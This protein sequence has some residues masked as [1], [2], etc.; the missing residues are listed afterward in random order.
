MYVNESKDPL[1]LNLKNLFPS[2]DYHYIE[3]QNKNGG[4]TATWN[5]GI[6][7][8]KKHD[9]ETII[10]S[11]D[12]IVFSK[13]ILHILHV[14][15]N[16][17]NIKPKYYG[18]ITNNPGNRANRL[19]YGIESKNKSPYISQ[20]HKNYINLNGFFMVFSISILEKNKFNEKYYFDP[21]KPFA[22]NE[23]EWFN[24]FKRINGQPIIVPK[25]FIY[26]Y[27]LKTWR[28]NIQKNDK[29]I[30]TINT[31][32]Y[33]G[34]NIYIKGNNNYDTLY[35]TDNFN[36]FKKC[37]LLNIIPFLVVHSN[38]KLIQR[39]IKS[40][41]HIYLPMQYNTS[42]YIDGNCRF[43][44]KKN[45]FDYYKKYLQKYDIICFRHPRNNSI[46]KEMAEVNF[47]RLASHININKVKNI[48]DNDK[49]FN[50]KNLTET[51]VLI[52]KHHN[53]VKFNE[54]WSHFI[55]ICHRDQL[56]FDYLIHKHNAR[57]LRLPYKD[58]PCKTNK[59]INPRNRK[60]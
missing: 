58:K 41:P 10:L 50:D 47:N 17:P 38:S 8:C 44:S 60:V 26:H 37:Q 7:E 12:D 28:T 9:C 11:N 51:N 33:E 54:D 25:T 39:L 52:R 4:L 19:Q 43:L 53:I 18:P 45:L 30:Y 59:H 23:V 21:S 24:R 34:S 48:I 55:S 1:T 6:D 42:I 13:S 22:G 40:S 29:C 14:C 49:K 36:L 35:F 46:E 20:Q 5:S 27:K 57:A 31:G 2:I 16:D 32:G 15:E 56:S 3:N